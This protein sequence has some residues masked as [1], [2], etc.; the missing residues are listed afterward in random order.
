MLLRYDD[1]RIRRLVSAR[2]GSRRA[3]LCALQVS[4]CALKRQYQKIFCF[5]FFHESAYPKPLKITIGYSDFFAK[6]AEIFASQGAPL[7]STTLPVERWSAVLK[8]FT[9]PHGF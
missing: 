3:W 5:R 7:V 4:K 9:S 6:F 1:M 2:N 8:A